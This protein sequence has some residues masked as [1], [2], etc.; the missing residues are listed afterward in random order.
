MN[1]QPNCLAADAP[2]VTMSVLEA[3]EGFR[4]LVRA[5]HLLCSLP[6][7]E[8]GDRLCS[9]RG[10]WGSGPYPLPSG[11]A[12]GTAAFPRRRLSTR[13]CR[14]EG[15]PLQS[16]CTARASLS[17]PPAQLCRGRRVGRAGHRYCIAFDRNLR[18]NALA[19]ER[20]VRSSCSSAQTYL[21][22]LGHIR[23]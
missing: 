16:S 2:S 4:G 7:R 3:G 20:E 14:P 17:I 11:S 18:I 15:S 21:R 22:S 10:S 9:Q 23:R 19:N 13:Y 1:A 12:A 6:V 8:T 5:T